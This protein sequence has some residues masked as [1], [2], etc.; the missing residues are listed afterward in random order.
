MAGARIEEP[1]AA[2]E[3]IDVASIVGIPLMKGIFLIFL[4]KDD[5]M[6]VHY[7]VQRMTSLRFNKVY[8]RR[9]HGGL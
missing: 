5:V 9:Q 7:Y 3:G 6:M 8:R 2:K 4:Y 1:K